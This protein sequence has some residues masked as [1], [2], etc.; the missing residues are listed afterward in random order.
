MNQTWDA[1]AAR[2][3][4]ILN[5]GKFMIRF[6]VLLLLLTHFLTFINSS[7]IRMSLIVYIYRVIYFN[8]YD[9]RS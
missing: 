4:K 3:I 7:S 8:E 2:L 1:Q 9:Q 6:D 5:T